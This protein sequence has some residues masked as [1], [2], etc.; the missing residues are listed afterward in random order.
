MYSSLPGYEFAMKYKYELYTFAGDHHQ[1]HYQKDNIQLEV[2]IDGDR[3]LA[4][5]YTYVKL[6]RCEIGWFSLPN[7]NFRIFEIQIRNI[8]NATGEQ[9]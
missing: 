2:K 9:E 7:R 5:L 8:L 6:V 4:R 3:L 1:A